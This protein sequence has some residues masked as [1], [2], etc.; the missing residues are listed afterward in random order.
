MIMLKNPPP[1]SGPPAPHGRT[2][3]TRVRLSEKQK[4]F[5]GAVFSDNRT[6]RQAMETLRIRP[7]ILC[8]WLQKPPFMQAL[9]DR[10]SVYQRQIQ[11]MASREAVPAI[12]SMMLFSDSG[13]PQKAHQA[14]RDLWKTYRGF[15]K[16]AQNGNPS[17]HQNNGNQRKE[18]VME[19]KLVLQ[20]PK[21]L[22]RKQ[23]CFLKGVLEEEQSM[24]QVMEENK[25][26]PRMLHA[27]LQQPRFLQAVEIRMARF[28]LQARIEA[29]RSACQAVH[30]LT[31]L[32]CRSVKHDVVRQAGM[33]LLKIHHALD[34]DWTSGKVAQKCAPTAKTPVKLAQKGAPPV[35]S[36][37]KMCAAV[38]Q[39]TKNPRFRFIIAE[40]CKNNQETG[41]NT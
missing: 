24:E 2:A 21:H 30:S 20:N 38:R 22:T 36:R 19:T 14:C 10:L 18:K 32:V 3:S 5:L 6:V 9:Q 40:N 39:K 41:K 33:D 11:I 16:A 29:A 26:S 7:A 27:W 17:K 12:D 37:P 1:A 34:A 35:L 28:H 4:A 15:Q 23:T 8:N 25:I 31:D 13:D